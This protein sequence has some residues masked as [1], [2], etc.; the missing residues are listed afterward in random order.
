MS[1]YEVLIPGEGPATIDGEPL[2]PA[3]GQSVHEAVLDQ[4]RRRADEQG[5]PVQ[6]AMDDGLAS[7]HFVLEVSPDGS[8]RLLTSTGAPVADSLP[9]P[10]SKPALMPEPDVTTGSGATA[11]ADALAAPLPSALAGRIGRVNALAA[12]GRLDDAYALATAPR[13]NLADAA[14]PG[15]PR[16][17]EALA[18]EAYLAHLRGDPHEATVLAL[19]VAGARRRAGDPRAAEDMVR[20]AAAWQRLDDDHAVVVHGRELLRLW[21]R[22]DRRGLLPPVHAELVGGVRRRV[23]GLAERFE[24]PAHTKSTG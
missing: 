11:V 18:L 17:V 21:G 22:L 15:D 1:R 4:L 19:G 6:A 7:G 20:A 5:G 3:P 12:D 14:G 13:E 23:D 8:S 16:T 10:E 2:V 24:T 9:G